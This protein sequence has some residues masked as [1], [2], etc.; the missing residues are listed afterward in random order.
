MNFSLGP[1]YEPILIFSTTVFGVLLYQ[2]NI[3]NMKSARV[4][5]R[6][7]HSMAELDSPRKRPPEPELSESE[8]SAS[9]LQKYKPEQ[10][11]D[12][13]Q[14]LAIF[15]DIYR[16][17]QFE[18][19]YLIFTFFVLSI[20]VLILAHF[21]LN[22]K[23]V[24][25][26]VIGYLDFYVVLTLT[27]K[28]FF[29][30]SW[31]LELSDD[32]IYS[33]KQNWNMFNF[34]ISATFFG[35][36]FTLALFCIYLVS[37][38]HQFFFVNHT[39]VEPKIVSAVHE[40]YK[41][42]LD[43]LNFAVCF[44]FYIVGKNLVFILHNI[45][46][47]YSIVMNNLRLSTD[48][49]TGT[50]N[51]T[52]Y[53][54]SYFFNVLN[55]TLKHNI[56]ITEVIVFSTLFLAKFKGVGRNF[57]I[58]FTAVLLWYFLCFSFIVIICYSFT[59]LKNYI[60]ITL[61]MRLGFIY[62]F[63]TT[64]VVVFYRFLIKPGV[65]II[66]EENF[67]IRANFTYLYL[68]LGIIMAIMFS[69]THFYTNKYP[70]KPIKQFKGESTRVFPYNL[71]IFSKIIVTVFSL[72]FFYVFFGFFG[73]G[74]VVYFLTLED[75]FYKINKI[76]F[77]FDTYLNLILQYCKTCHI[78]YLDLNNL[79]NLIDKNYFYHFVVLLFC[80]P[81]YRLDHLRY[82]HQP[83]SPSSLGIEDSA[84]RL[85]GLIFL[86]FILSRI[87]L[88]IYTRMIWENY[89][90]AESSTQSRTILEDWEFNYNNKY[91]FILL[92]IGFL[93]VFSVIFVNF[94]THNSL[95]CVILGNTIHI[96]QLIFLNK[97][98]IKKFF[99]GQVNIKAP[100]FLT[101]YKEI[102][103][104]SF[105]LKSLC[106]ISFGET[107]IEINKVLLFLYFFFGFFKIN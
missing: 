62:Y 79:F 26:F 91:R 47:N 83:D 8:V 59:R 76:S 104:S 20:S 25:C 15:K 101:I 48:V 93:L 17:F 7:M 107:L 27:R 9:S 34:Y 11:K 16:V 97:F 56:I 80:I 94:F 31:H 24:T 13:R 81:L 49:S 98:R 89:K 51:L 61:V 41:F 74:L 82:L 67:Q 53:S 43:F 100:N 99:G 18:T 65:Y 19:P 105:Y 71:I 95:M 5:C 70:S 69:F 86:A 96:F 28:L 6:T 4:F 29:K 78:H 63:V 75:S 85:I 21:Y 46:E 37:L 87:F 84:F 32:K 90:Y 55:R 40:K 58:L 57:F 52:F 36:N 66:D 2:L 10:K 64:F 88:A 72:Y 60:K 33:K 12:P 92:S 102:G 45:W 103:N 73:I 23:F 22:V 42:S 77:I 50:Q 39:T 14:E 68:F 54:L 38:Y 44:F 30:L 106:E 3:F 35:L 1:Y